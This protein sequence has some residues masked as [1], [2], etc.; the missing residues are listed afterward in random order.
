M[1]KN[2]LFAIVTVATLNLALGTLSCCSQTSIPA[3]N[4]SGT[5]TL[6]GSPYNIQGNI[7][8]ADATTLTIQPGVTV[9]FNG[10]YKLDVQGRLLAIGTSADTIIFKATNTTNGWRGIQFNNT[11]TTNDTSKVYYCKLKYGKGNGAF[12]FGYFSKI[13]ISNCYISNCTATG[14]GGGICCDY[15][16]P[17]ITNN[18]ISNNTASSG[19]GISCLVSNSIIANNLISNNTSTG[20]G[21][22]I[23]LNGSNP[24]IFN[25]AINN[26][27]A[28]NGGGGG[29]ELNSCNPTISNNIISN[30]TAILGGGINCNGGNSIV[31]NNTI[32]NNRASSTGGGILFCATNP[33]NLNNSIGNNSAAM[34][35]AFYFRNGS[36]PVL[37]N[38]ILWGNTAGSGAEVFLE[39]EGSDPSFFYFD[40]QGGSAAFELNGN[41]YT[42]TFQNNLDIDP[43][44][45]A[46]SGGSGTSFNGVTAN[47]SLQ[48]NSPC[49]NTGDP[50]GTYAAIDKAGNPRVTICR[51]DM[52]AFEYQNGIPLTTAISIQPILCNGG[53]ATITV[54]PAGGTPTYTYLWG[55]GHTN[56][57]ETGLTPGTYT[58]TVTET[59]INCSITKNITIQQPPAL[60]LISSTT[61][62][63]CTNNNGSASVAVSGGVHPYTYLWSTNNSNTSDTISNL[64]AGTYSVTVTDSN[65]CPI[66]DSIH[67]ISQ[68][69]TISLISHFANPTCSNN[70]GS[71]SITASGGTNTFSYL[72]STNNNNTDDTISNLFAG[73]YSVIVTDTNGCS[74]SDSVHLI[75]QFSTISLN[76]IIVDASCFNNDGALSLVPNGGSAP[77][78]FVWSNGNHTQNLS[79]IGSGTYSVIVSDT[80][81]CF[82]NDTLIVVNLAPSSIPICM[83]TVD[84]TSTKNVIVWEKPTGAPIDSFK[85][86]REIASAYVHIGSV[87]YSSLSEFTDNSNGINPNTTSYKYKLSVLDTCGNESPLS[88]DHQTVHLQ[89]SAAIPQGVNLSWN[90]YLGFTFSQ[91][92]ILR[93]DLGNGN[94]HTLDS[95]SFGI[96]TY[97][98]TDILPNASYIVEAKRPTPCVSTRQINSRN[99]SKSN[100]TSLL[101]AVGESSNDLSVIIYPNPTNGKFKIE[102]GSS[103]LKNNKNEIIIY[104]VL[105]EKVFQSSSING[106]TLNEID[107]SAS[108]KGIYFVQ[109]YNGVKN[110]SEKIIIQ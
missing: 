84:S 70:D 34:G 89:I 66:L 98:R 96:T 108:P 42:G 93:D 48:N 91:Y 109:I 45:V 18:T 23:Y 57:T 15:S 20:N 71:A 52:G 65:G 29:I 78:S 64:L 59:G 103:Q 13:I 41:S 31:T 87:A 40:I 74:A 6:A 60:S 46:P 39:D 30:N 102:L 86:Y 44:F 92:R 8:I 104:N 83:V 33:I 28:I 106:Q 35:G 81:G 90:D 25:N 80:N 94:W 97:T 99:S 75:T 19:G 69:P 1:K 10:T 12:Y 77:Y 68:T 4:V 101:T 32:I 16:S 27:S 51:I 63:I 47:W 21:G 95:V 5:W 14:G 110:H 72:W 2:L 53:T 37:R 55:N 9:N 24:S 67:L 82:A 58:V 17:I 22:G 61:K 79:G 56:A 38:S 54:M 62:P 36:S 76:P 85:I 88:A 11:P 73:T 3:G 105:G 26:N 7:T 50:A 100:T 107:L 43:F 49:I